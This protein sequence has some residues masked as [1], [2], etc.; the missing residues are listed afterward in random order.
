MSKITHRNHFVPQFYLQQWTDEHGK[1]WS[2][3]TLVAH[4]KVPMWSH[5]PTRTVAY[6]MD[7]YTEVV[8]GAELDEFEHWV[9]DESS[10][11]ASHLCEEI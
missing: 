6:R 4:E 2:Y 9:N 10:P 5:I 8:D 1:L 3:R 7:L 11:I